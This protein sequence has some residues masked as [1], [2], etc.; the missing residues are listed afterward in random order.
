MKLPFFKQLVDGIEKS[1]AASF[2][3]D[4]QRQNQED[5]KSL[6]KYPTQSTSRAF[7]LTPN[8]VYKDNKK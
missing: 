7:K 1:L 3:T 2:D 4:E 6:D 5:L 8:L